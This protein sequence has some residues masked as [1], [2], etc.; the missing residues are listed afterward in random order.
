MNSTLTSP[1][2]VEVWYVPTY[3]ERSFSMRFSCLEAP[4]PLV[5][6][7]ISGQLTRFFT[8]N[9]VLRAVKED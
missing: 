8:T 6:S 2:S 7:D 5:R 1:V 9:A 4:T 3:I